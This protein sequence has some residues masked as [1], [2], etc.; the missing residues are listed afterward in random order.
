[1]NREAPT[2]RILKNDFPS[3]LMLIMIG[4]VWFLTIA[5]G[6]LKFL[7]KRRGGGAI[8]VDSTMMINFVVIAAVVTLLCGWFAARRI[9]AIKRVIRSGP[10]VKGRI[11]SIGFVKDR[12]RV[13][14]E[15]L[16]EGQTYQA[17]NA[18]WKN[19]ETTKLK[20]GGEVT[21]ILDPNKPSRAFIAS[22]YT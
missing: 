17:G 14:Y 21:L 2:G 16:Y 5:G 9:A 18:I 1:M 4:V 20:R 7:P 15:Y 11:Q 3:L 12:G 6:V 13:D 8:E 10:E 22:L 19:R